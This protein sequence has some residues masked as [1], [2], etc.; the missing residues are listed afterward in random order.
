MPLERLFTTGSLRPQDSMRFV[1]AGS[2]AH[3]MSPQ[4]SVPDAWSLESAQAFAESLCEN[5]PAATQAIEENTLPSWLWQRRTLGTETCPENSV[6]QVFERI[7]GAAT[8]RGWKAGLWENEIEAS[9]FFDEVQALLVTRR[10]VLA[11]RDMARLGLDWAYGLVARE[12]VSHCTPI[13][14]TN[15]LI[16]QNETIDSILRR[17][18]PQASNKWTSYLHSSRTKPTTHIAFADT[19]AE[20]GSLPTYHNVP[21]AMLN[22]AAFY[23]TE[24]TLDLTAL[25]YATRLA[26]LLM[27]LHHDDL[28][29]CN[30]PARSL[31]LGL[32]NLGS[33]LMSLALPYD[34]EK[35][36]ATAANLCAII[37]G[38][39]TMTSAQLAARLGSC[40][41]F[42]SQREI[43]L[44][45]LRNK[46]RAT[47]GEKN[48]YD[49]LSILPQTLGLESGV[50]LELISAARHVCSEALRLTQEHGL[51]HLQVTSLYEDAD[52]GILMDATTQGVQAESALTCDYA[53]DDEH[54]ERFPLPAIAKALDK[55]GYDEADSKAIQDH[56]AG[57]RTLVGA[58]CINHATLREKGFNEATLARIEAVL[59]F[60][61]HLRLAFTPWVVGTTFCRTLFGMTEA[62]L[63]NPHFDMLRHLGFTSQE[64]SV[65][66]AFCCGHRSA[67]GVLELEPKHHSIFD[68]AETMSTEAHLAMAGAMQPF[69]SGDANLRLLVP[70]SLSAE[71]RGDIVIKAWELGL[72]GLTLEVDAP[73]KIAAQEQPQLMK[74][75]SPR[76]A[77]HDTKLQPSSIHALKPK[78]PSR[79]VTLKQDGST[80]K[81][82]SVRAKR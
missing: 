55:L 75:Q 34:S 39:A 79:A 5:R 15:A 14:H 70:A 47:F 4:L 3:P 49:H 36:R 38:T 40:A 78:A 16:L 31:A 29:D 23:T 46:L 19:I 69:I 6:L 17:T 76:M 9:I 33:L 22:M 82:A 44:R 52:I 50:D 77:A 62:E 43:V 42:A 68:T 48:D 37:T 53:V 21:R 61:D 20:W 65:A 28:T 27:E 13:H 1:L 12:K 58:P 72:K 60:V 64:I 51:R 18:Q 63:Q 66:N 57:Y 45:T 67:K 10:L 59:P 81:G 25:Q 73:Y 32:G 71:L 80:T 54:F 8:Y 35:A 74:R 30:D 2:E 7:A 24:G 56:I 26:V 41:S 11:P